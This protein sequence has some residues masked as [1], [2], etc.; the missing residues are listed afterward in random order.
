MEE[1]AKMTGVPLN[2]VYSRLRLAKDALRSRVARDPV[3]AEMLEQA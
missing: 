3:L 1:V 2:T